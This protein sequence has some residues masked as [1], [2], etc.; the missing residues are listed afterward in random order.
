MQA[1][2]EQTYPRLGTIY[3]LCSVYYPNIRQRSDVLNR[4]NFLKTGFYE[5]INIK[6]LTVNVIVTPV[7]SFNLQLVEEWNLVSF[8]VNNIG[9]KTVSEVVAS[10]GNNLVRVYEYDPATPGNPWKIYDP[11]APPFVNTLSSLSP[12]LGYWLL[13]STG[14]NLAVTGDILPVDNTSWGIVAGWQLV[15]WGS[16]TSGN[17]AGIA[18]A[19]GGTVR[20]YGYDPQ[21]T[22]SPWKL[23]DSTTPPI[24]QTLSQLVRG[25]GY[26]LY[27][28]PT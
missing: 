5:G 8:P 17:P 12:E 27:W 23:Y 1:E 19:L 18:G 13:L 4:R 7:P 20:I 22:L 25:Y 26:W 6:S 14:D 3:S 10:L 28:Q 16:D 11:N 21:S 24:A 2:L 15:G 9:T